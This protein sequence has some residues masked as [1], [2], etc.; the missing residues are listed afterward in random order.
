M[1]TQC[2][3]R[4]GFTL[5]E[6]LVV[7]AIIAVLIALLLPAVQAAREAARR[8]QCTNNI[9][10]MGLAAANFE[11]TNGTFPPSYGQYP[12]YDSTGDGRANVLANMLPFLEQ[13]AGYSSFNFQYDITG[14]PSSSP[15]IYVNSTSQ[16]QLINAFVC[17]SDP[18]S[19]RF[20]NL[21]YANYVACLGATAALE[22]G[23]TYTNMEPNSQFL[24]IYIAAVDYGQPKTLASG[25]FN[26]NYQK[27]PGVSIS[28]ITDGTSN[29]AAF[30]E[31]T[32]ANNNGSSPRPPVTDTT[33]VNFQ[34]A[35]FTSNQIPPNPCATAF[36]ITY[37]GQEYYRNFT[38]TGYY[39]HTL[40]PN[41]PLLD[42]GTYGDS[43]AMNNFSRMH[44]AARS[45][46][47]GGVN[48]GFADGSVRF[49]KNTVNLMTY[50][51]LGTRSGGEVISADQY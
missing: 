11:S 10:Q 47:S 40:T 36:P 8:S 1:R 41:S 7:I 26:T 3:R 15:A 5:I 22:A 23:S 16:F 34:S 38:M 45:K 6:L 46:H 2:P 4:R 27:V 21:G 13:G 9:K 19:T 50:F 20:N 14:T 33:R 29:T 51:A 37:R 18:S 28:A 32:R 25:A 49:I 48:V 44:I 39:N 17:P 43:A 42:C 24:G 12:Q 30:S 31:T 35:A